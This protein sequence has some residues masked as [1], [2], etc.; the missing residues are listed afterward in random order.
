MIEVILKVINT[1]YLIQSMGTITALSMFISPILYKGDYKNAMKSAI[2]LG[3][4]IFFVGMLE[5]SHLGIAEN[6]PLSIWIQPITI[7]TVVGMAYALGLFI[8]IT[9]HNLMCKKHNLNH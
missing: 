2:V 4:Y 5:Y 3:G 7:L 9:I 8:G 6:R 1:P